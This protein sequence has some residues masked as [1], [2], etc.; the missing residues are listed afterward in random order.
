MR[1]PRAERTVPPVRRR[2]SRAGKESSVRR[3]YNRVPFPDA[4]QLCAEVAGR[5]GIGQHQGVLVV[6]PVGNEGGPDVGERNPHELGLAAVVAAAGVRLPVNPADGG[7]VGVDVVT[8][9]VQPAHAEVAGS[10]EDVE[11]TITRSP[12]DSVRTDGPTCS[13][14]P[15]NSCPK[16]MPTRV[17]GIIP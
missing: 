7:G 9:R 1:Q 13:T 10:A 15:M 16:V 14:T 6:H 12:L 17:S 2:V 8:V 3:R 11:G 4:T 5:A